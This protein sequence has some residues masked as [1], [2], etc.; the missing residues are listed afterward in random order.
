[1]FALAYGS[2]SAQEA[3]K[4]IEENYY[5]FLSL[6]GVVERASLGYRTLSDSVWNFIDAAD[7]D[8]ANAYPFCNT[9]NIW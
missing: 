1:M 6:T 3:L 5:D 7:K 8:E 2:I 9:E 4:S